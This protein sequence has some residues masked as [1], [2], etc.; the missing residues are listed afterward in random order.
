VYHVDGDDVYVT[1][2]I[3]YVYIDP[4]GGS[5]FISNRPMWSSDEDKA[6]ALLY[7]LS[8]FDE[9][10]PFVYTLESITV[11][12]VSNP[13]IVGSGTQCTAWGTYTDVVDP[14]DITSL[15]V[16]TSDYESTFHVSVNN[17]GEAWGESA[18]GSSIITA[19]MDLIAGTLEITCNA[20]P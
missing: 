18:G 15:V 19:T 7:T 2:P 9:V 10:A 4:N 20:V 11:E 16:W 3:G 12:T 14:I 5:L 8:I 1:G 6:Y 17:T 13:V